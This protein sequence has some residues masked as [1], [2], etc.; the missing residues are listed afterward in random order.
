MYNE[1]FQRWTPVRKSYMTSLAYDRS[2]LET[3]DER[4][5]AGA[6]GYPHSSMLSERLTDKPATGYEYP[7]WYS[8]T[9]D[10]PSRVFQALKYNLKLQ[11][12]QQQNYNYQ[13]SPQFSPKSG[14]STNSRLI[15]ELS[16]SE[17]QFDGFGRVEALNTKEARLKCLFNQPI[18]DSDVSSDI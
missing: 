8:G 15:V 13:A 4:D 11:Q 12:Q 6:I 14:S 7:R 16:D 18:S 2:Q 1:Y 3:V 17:P 5:D 9:A 10:S